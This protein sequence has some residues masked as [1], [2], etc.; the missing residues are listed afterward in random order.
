M[1]LNPGLTSSGK[2]GTC[3]P[4]LLFGAESE[5]LVYT[6]YH[7][8]YLIPRSYHSILESQATNISA[9]IPFVMDHFL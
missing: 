5:K 3:F 9:H 1:C 7:F 2:A 6:D 8:V 4:V